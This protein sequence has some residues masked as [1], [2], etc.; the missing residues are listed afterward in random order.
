MA[1]YEKYGFVR[2]GAIARYGSTPHDESRT[3]GY[4]HWCYSDERVEDM[5]RPS[6]MMAL[7][8]REPHLDPKATKE[9]EKGLKRKP[10]GSVAGLLKAT[11]KTPKQSKFSK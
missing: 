8:L 3:V 2:V 6:Y 11:W 10:I 9:K 7:R 1:F 4:R 5:D